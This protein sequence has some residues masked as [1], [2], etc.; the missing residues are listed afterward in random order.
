MIQSYPVRDG[1]FRN[2]GGFPEFVKAAHEEESEE[3]S[4]GDSIKKEA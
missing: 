4:N 3:E 1:M 2:D